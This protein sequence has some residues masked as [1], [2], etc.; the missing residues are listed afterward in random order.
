MAYK[1]T[2]H[3]ASS[4]DNMQLRV[5][6][7]KAPVVSDGAEAIKSEDWAVTSVPNTGDSSSKEASSPYGAT[8]AVRSSSPNLASQG[9]DPC[10]SQNTEAN[11]HLILKRFAAARA[12][13]H[14]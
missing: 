1:G 12:A 13:V 14:R 2:A 8:T 9:R 11:Q 4:E 3:L 10:R 5:G 7:R 6:H